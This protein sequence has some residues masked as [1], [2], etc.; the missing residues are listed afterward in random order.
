MVLGYFLLF[1]FDQS[2]FLF[3]ACLETL[4]DQVF[5]NVLWD[6][7]LVVVDFLP[8]VVD[9]LHKHLSFFSI[10]LELFFQFWGLEQFLLEIQLSKQVGSVICES[11]PYIFNSVPE[12]LYFFSGDW[13]LLGDRMF[14]SC[15][16]ESDQFVKFINL[17]S[18]VF[19]E[20]H[21]EWFHV[22]GLD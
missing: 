18:C 22:E 21:D 1:G 13:Q 8:D 17:A 19:E 7:N 5:R 20:G 4:G 2:H 16:L 10:G 15:F 14:K 3:V 12:A 9:G 6:G 11:W